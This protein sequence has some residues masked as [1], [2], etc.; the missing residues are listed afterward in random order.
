MEA[1]IDITLPADE[2]EGTAAKISQWLIEDGAEVTEGEPIL[3]L[4]TD[5]VNM[6]VCAPATGQLAVINKHAGDDVEPETVLGQLRVIEGGT[7]GATDVESAAI[8]P[9]TD[10]ASETVEIVLP[11][12]QLEGTAAK[13]AQW[14]VDVGETV[15]EGDP[16]VELETDKVNME[17]CAPASGVLLSVA[18]A[19][20]DEVQPDAVLGLIGSAGAAQPQASAAAA[21]VA[22]HA[23]QQTAAT[24]S[25]SQSAVPSAA[26][27][28]QADADSARHLVGPAVRK[29]LRENNL[30]INLIT[31]SGRRGRVTRDDVLAYLKNPQ[32]RILETVE[33]V[34][35]A[36]PVSLPASGMPSREVPH[37]PMRKAIAKHMVESLL[38]TSPHVTSV[39]EM[40]MSNIIE[41]RRWHKKEFAD[42]GVKLTFTAYFLAATVKA[43]QVVPQMNARYHDHA[44]EIFDDINIGV[45]TALGDD[46]LVVPVV[47]R[48]QEKRLFDIAQALHAQTDKARAG[49]LTPADMKNGTFTISN[50][51]VSGSLFAAP[52]IINQPQVA[53]LGIGKLEK[54]VVVT[55]VDGKDEM[56]I[57]PMC[58]V[59][60]SIDHRAV[61]AFQTNQFLS[62]FVETIENWGQ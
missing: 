31:G 62:V 20:G 1:L 12:D 53:I 56:Q 8:E 15:N 54:R 26:T 29:L 16:L 13:L 47:Q 61:D 2:L 58:Y 51:G 50:H 6:E 37:T 22:S 43:M 41:H 46:G 28:A 7:A 3:E 49:K 30:D 60:L 48:V 33:T 44:L 27:D 35:T 24:Q 11:A 19:P 42:E 52:I 39:F 36:A 40:D 14:L 55:E 17:V 21:P 4:E 10:A 57:K 59:S 9:A 25:A 34:K 5:K 23:A 38:H 32:S 45:G 18:N